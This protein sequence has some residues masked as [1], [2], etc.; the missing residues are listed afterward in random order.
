MLQNGDSKLVMN[1]EYRRRL[2]G[3]LYGAI[4]LDAGNVWSTSDYFLDETDYETPEEKQ[5]CEQ[6]NDNLA[7]MKFKP[8]NLFKQLATGTGLGLRYDLDFLVIRVD[9]GFGL[10]LP[11]DTG[12]SGYFNIR[13]FR[14][15]QTL[16]FAVGY[17]F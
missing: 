1:L 3:S 8:K 2:S 12:K 14:D 5:F 6:W 17:P 13:K 4:F 7:D 15:M 11:Y 16:H 10:H 9:W